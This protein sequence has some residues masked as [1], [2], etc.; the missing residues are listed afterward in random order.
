MT[1]RDAETVL[2]AEVWPMK[3]PRRGLIAWRDCPHCQHGHENHEYHCTGGC[4]AGFRVRTIGFCG[5]I[6][7]G[8][9]EAAKRLVSRWRF[10]RVRFAEPLKAMLAA[11]G[12]TEAQ[13]DGASKEE[14]AALLCGRTPRQAMQ[15]LGTEW[16]RNLIADDFW[17]AAWRAA[18]ER[19]QPR[20]TCHGGFAPLRLIVADDV[21]FANEAKAIRDR[22]GLVVRIERPGAGTT[23]G[24]GHASERADFVPDRIIRNR[25]SLAEL[26]AQIDA[27]AM[28]LRE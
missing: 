4:M 25:G 14:P 20:F 10:S 11:L 27:L 15:W 8:K 17:I 3:P 23:T 6:G 19:V 16:G 7:A 1:M 21:R 22:G 12:L 18:V 24:A 26:Q 13:L 9:S 5:P 28:E 2:E